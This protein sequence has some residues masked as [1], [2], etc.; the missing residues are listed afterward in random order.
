VVGCDSGANVTLTLKALAVNDQAQNA[1]PLQAVTSQTVIT[2]FEQPT[3]L[4]FTRN[5]SSHSSLIGYDLTFNESVTGLT[6]QSFVVHGTGCVMSKLS[7]TGNSYTLWLSDCA[8]GVS[9]YVSLKANAV[10]DQ[11]ANLGPMVAIDSPTNV[12]DDIAPGASITAVARAAQTSQPAFDIVFTEPVQGIALNSISHSGTATGCT[13]TLASTLVGLSYRVSASSC[14][15][16]TLRLE[17]PAKSVTDATGNLGPATQEVSE[18]VVIDKTPTPTGPGIAGKKA[19][20]KLTPRVEV[21]KVK[22]VPTQR[23]VI[24]PATQL[25]PAKAESIPVAKSAQGNPMGLGVGAAG[26]LMAGA[27]VAWRRRGY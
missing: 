11:A 13:F 18:L 26:V 9:V 21:P 6:A 23:P 3:P 8:Q 19:V 16:G 27:W 7:G 5:P 4:T 15:A 14:S 2:D 17:L 20:I 22:V 10:S 12:I 25:V 24:K 1:G